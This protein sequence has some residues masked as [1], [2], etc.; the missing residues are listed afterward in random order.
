MNKA[1]K[2]KEEKMTKDEKMTATK[3]IRLGKLIAVHIETS[4]LWV[5]FVNKKRCIGVP[6]VSG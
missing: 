1:K 5:V 2:A 4:S 3:V 6:L